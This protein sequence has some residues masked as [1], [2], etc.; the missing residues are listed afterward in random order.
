MRIGI[1]GRE[2]GS[3]NRNQDKK[4]DNADAN[5]NFWVGRDGAEKARGTLSR[6]MQGS[7]RSDLR[8]DNICGLHRLIPPLAYT[9][10]KGDVEQLREKIGEQHGQG[11]HQKTSLN[12][13]VIVALHALI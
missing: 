2:Q 13:G 4:D 1:I 11:D 12:Q 3:N 10:I 7:G 9:R 5:G 6:S 8:I